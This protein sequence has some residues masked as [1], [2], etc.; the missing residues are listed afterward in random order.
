LLLT[1]SESEETLEAF[2]RQVRPGGPGWTK[3]RLKTGLPPDQDLGLDV[4]KAIAAIVLLLGTL[5]SAGGFL[6]L[7]E[8][9]GWVCLVLAVGGGVVLRQLSKTRILPTPRPGL[10]DHD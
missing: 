8:T 5:L 10:D 1:S 6:L 3:Q 2:Y 9:L 7:Q 4:Q